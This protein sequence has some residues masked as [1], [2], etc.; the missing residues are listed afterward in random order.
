V[1]RFGAIM[2][3]LVTP[4]TE[5]GRLDEAGMRRLVEYVLAGGVRGVVVLG[6]SGEPALL[7]A[8]VRRR[9][10]D[11]ALEAVNRRAIVVAGTGEPGTTATVE[12]TRQASQA[13][14]DAAIVV[15]PYYFVHDQ[16]AVKRHYR[17]I[18][19]A[20]ELPLLA[21]HIPG[22]TK[23]AIQVETLQ[24]LAEEGT[25]WGVKDSGGDFGYQQRLVDGPG[26]LTD[27]AVL[28]GS[29]QLI[30]A[31]LAYG[32]DGAIS[33]R[34]QITPEVVVALYDAA[35]AGDWTRARAIQEQMRRLGP[36]LGPGWHQAVKGALSALGICGPQVALPNVRW[37]DAELAA[38]RQRLESAR[39]VG[40]FDPATVAPLSS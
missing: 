28:Q 33:V 4:L 31:S 11:V 32:G 16:M 22:L 12:S 17:A 10:L 20:V 38:Q 8:D 37:T 30:F 24:E 29:D 35:V 9:A 5:D 40:L 25:L 14:A 26:R 39:V 1:K 18:R 6:S 15:P 23:V 21:Y 3:P 27:F 34:A 2:T 19:E 36:A 7:Q 13:G